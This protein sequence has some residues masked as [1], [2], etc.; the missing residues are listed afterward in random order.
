V[1]KVI[2]NWQRPQWEGDWEVVKRSGKDEPN[3]I[4]IYMCME[5][6]LGISVYCHLYL[7]LAKPLCLSYYFLCFLFNKIVKE[8]RAGSAWKRGGREGQGEAAGVGERD[9]PNN[10]YT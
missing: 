10:V 4:V 6:I 7:K 9:G 1:N 5:A 3:C 2:L 8:S